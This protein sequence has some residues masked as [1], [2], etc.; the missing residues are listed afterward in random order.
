[1]NSNKIDKSN[2]N[3]TRRENNTQSKKSKILYTVNDLARLLQL[4]PE[5]IRAMARRGEI[6]G[7]KIGRV[8]RFD[9]IKINSW[10]IDLEE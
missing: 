3:H 5:T 2:K 8:W 9:P 7:I 1:M 4:E 10:L 6:P